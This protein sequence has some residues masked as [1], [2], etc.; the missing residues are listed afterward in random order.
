[1]NYGLEKCERSKVKSENSTI[2][3]TKPMFKDL[4]SEID[5]N[6]RGDDF[7]LDVFYK[8]FTPNGV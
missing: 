5:D 7:G 4:T 3:A 2:L 8:Y 6:I 1:M